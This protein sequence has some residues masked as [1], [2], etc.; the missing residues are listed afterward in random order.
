MHL[1]KFKQS[2]KFQE[3]N[4]ILI[5]ENT[6]THLLLQGPIIYHEENIRNETALAVVNNTFKVIVNHLGTSI[7]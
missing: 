4:A 3:G 7:L 5:A 2:I 6:F 1:L